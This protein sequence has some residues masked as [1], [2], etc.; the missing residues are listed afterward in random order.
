[1]A[2][3]AVETATCPFCKEEILA[4]ALLCKHCGSRL[5]PEKLQ[6]GGTCPYCKEQIHPEATRCKHC[7]SDLASTERERGAGGGGGG[8]GCG[9]GGGQGPTR[10]LAAS[11]SLYMSGSG[12]PDPEC[13]HDCYWRCVDATGDA[14][15]CWIGCSYVCPES[16]LAR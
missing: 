10:Q 5:G 2:K 1:M 3:E 6:H 16:T 14:Q 4:G 7:R 13:F 12:F 15:W 9:G 11:R 8:C